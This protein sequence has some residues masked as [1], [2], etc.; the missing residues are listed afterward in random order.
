MGTQV[1]VHY[2]AVLTVQSILNFD[3]ASVLTDDVG[4]SEAVPNH[5]AD[6]TQPVHSHTYGFTVY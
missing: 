2:S 3:K 1:C 4:V 6:H 5:L